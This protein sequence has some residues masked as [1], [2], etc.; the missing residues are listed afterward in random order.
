MEKKSRIKKVL[1]IVPHMDDELLVGGSTICEFVNSDKWD[2]YIAF[3]TNGDYFPHESE[4]RQI[5]ALAANKTLGVDASHIFFLGYGDQWKSP[6]HIYNSEPEQICISHAGRDRTFAIESHPEYS[7]LTQKKHN[8]YNR[9][10]I[11]GDIKKL[12]VD[13]MPEVIFT[14]DFD[15][16]PDHRALLL[17][18]EESLREILIMYRAYAPLVLTKLAYEGIYTGKNDFFDSPLAPTKLY[19]SRIKSNPFLEW[20]NRIAFKT[21]S[22]CTTSNLNS[23]I[24]YSAAKCYKTQE[25]QYIMPRTINSD[26]VYWRIETENIAIFAR[27][28][29]SS[30]IA[31]YVNDF[32]SIDSDDINIREC[33]LSSSTWIP[34]NSDNQKEIKLTWDGPQNINKIVIYE[35]PDMRSHLDEI[36]VAA[37]NFSITMRLDNRN[38]KKHVVLIG[39]KSKYISVRILEGRNLP[40]ISE[41]EVF[42][43]RREIEA[44]GLPLT[45]IDTSEGTCTSTYD[46]DCGFL[47]MKFRKAKFALTEILCNKMFPNEFELR[48]KF[49][50]FNRKL[51]IIYKIRYCVRRIYK[52][53]YR[54]FVEK[55]N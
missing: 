30:G 1:Y 32:K 26:I 50:D 55:R 35:S 20:D 22:K 49:G 44:F 14:T 5:E 19:G 12:I 10:S 40:G 31:M 52:K 37:E 3:L 33:S 47:L 24:L 27:A 11:V 21:Y 36:M 42:D 45:H 34:D 23:N 25:I 41:I 51:I 53:A 4:T 29:A 38:T 9:R 46:R 39:K 2:V 7:Y 28:S 16:H 8:Y 13:L 15:A 6:R 18:L 48:K 17:F 43:K 54:Q